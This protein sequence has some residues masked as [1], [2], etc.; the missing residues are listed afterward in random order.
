MAAVV[1]EEHSRAVFNEE[2]DQQLAAMDARHAAKEEQDRL[3]MAKLDR[4]AVQS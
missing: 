2:R 4:E 1:N 3:I